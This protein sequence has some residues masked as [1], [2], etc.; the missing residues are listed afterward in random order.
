[1]RAGT[2]GEESAW[3]QSRLV[4]RAKAATHAPTAATFLPF[5]LL[6]D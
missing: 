1:M 3:G 2:S 4:R 6:L 5:L